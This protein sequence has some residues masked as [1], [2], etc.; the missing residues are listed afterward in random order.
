LCLVVTPSQS[1]V[2]RIRVFRCTRSWTCRTRSLEFD[3]VSQRCTCSPSR[4]I[5]PS[6]FVFATSVL[7]QFLFFNNQSELKASTSVLLNSPISFPTRSSP[8]TMFL[9]LFILVLATTV[10]TALKNCGTDQPTHQQVQ[11][12]QAL[13]IHASSSVDA[14]AVKGGIYINMMTQPAYTVVPVP[15]MSVW[16]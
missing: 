10:I 4:M 12:A 7:I 14:L 3:H 9:S 2:Y 5:V 8:V 13:S 11:D 15:A 6:N 16:V 1:T